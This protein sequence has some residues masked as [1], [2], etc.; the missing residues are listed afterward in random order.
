MFIAGTVGTQ[1]FLDQPGNPVVSLWGYHQLH[2]VASA[3]TMFG[4]VSLL[5]ACRRSI[6]TLIEPDV[7]ASFWHSFPSRQRNGVCAYD[8]APIVQGLGAM[9][10]ATGAQKYRRLALQGAQWLYGRNEAHAQMYDPTTGRCRDGITNGQPSDNFGAESAI[11]AGFIEL[12]RND[13]LDR[14]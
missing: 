8:V 2:A 4:D 6:E 5:S 12:A 13:L 3:A 1:Y 7:R 11:E 14:P 9:Y 10:A